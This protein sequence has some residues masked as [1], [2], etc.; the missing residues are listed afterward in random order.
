VR[1]SGSRSTRARPQSR[2]TGNGRA[3]PRRAPASLNWSEPA[4]RERAVDLDPDAFWQIHRCIIVNLAEIACA[5]CDFRGRIRI[6][7]KHRPETPPVSPPYA[8][9]F[10]QM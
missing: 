2:S 5:R 6:Q 8:Q 4:T 10:R 3:R 1:C 9:L 7:L